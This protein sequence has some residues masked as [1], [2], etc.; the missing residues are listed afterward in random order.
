MVL[1]TGQGWS[2]IHKQLANIKAK[3][4]ATVEASIND[5][6]QRTGVINP[7]M[8]KIGSSGDRTRLFQNSQELEKLVQHSTETYKSAKPEIK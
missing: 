5:K 1:E 7:L 3:T 6:D 4:K 8:L 2:C